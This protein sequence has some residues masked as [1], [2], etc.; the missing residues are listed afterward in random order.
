MEKYN[1]SVNSKNNIKEHDE[2]KY[3][4]TNIINN[5][6]S[7]DINKN[8]EK[9]VNLNEN[10]DSLNNI[11]NNNSLKSIN[12]N[13]E[14]V[15]SL[16]ENETN[17]NIIINNNSL[18]S[19]NKSNEKFDNL[20][21]NK[22]SLNNIINN[23]SINN[24]NKNCK[25][26]DNL[27]ENETNSNIIINNNSLKSINKSDEKVDSLNE[28]KDNLNNIINNDSI[29][30]INKNC[31]TIDSLHENEANSNN[32]I[33]ENAIKNINERY[34]K[35]NI[36]VAGKTGVGKSSLI[37]A[38]FKEEITET[39][40][41]TPVTE[42][43]NEITKN[44]VSIFDS[45]GIVLQNYEK[46]SEELKNF[47]LE[48]K[49]NENE[50]KHIHLAWV[51]IAE[52]SSRIEEAEK[53]LVELL[54]SLDIPVIIVLT[55]SMSSDTKFLEE[56]KNI[57]PKVNDNIIQVHA[58]EIKF[59]D[60]YILKPKN[61]NKLIENTN[62]FLSENKKIS[63]IASQKVFIDI[64]EKTVKNYINE[65]I[66]N[67]EFLNKEILNEEILKEKLINI[68]VYISWIFGI[69][70]EYELINKINDLLF[71]NESF[72]I[73]SEIKDNNNKEIIKEKIK[74]IYKK[75]S[76]SL[77]NLFDNMIKNNSD[78]Y[79]QIENHIT[80]EVDNDKQIQNNNTNSKIN[81]NRDE[82]KENSNF[83][84]NNNSSK[85]INKSDEKVDSLHENEA[86]SNNIIIENAI[87][88]INERYGK[89]NILVA[90][91]TGVGKSS[92]INAIFK[93]EITETGVG[94]PVTENIN[95]ITKNEVSIFDSKGIVLQNYEKVSEELK[96]FILEKKENE[97]ENKHIHL[98]WV[99]IAEGS[100]RIEEAEKDLVELLLSLDIPVIIVLTKSMSSDTKFL[101]EV[102]NICPKVN[103]NIIQ[104]HA[105]EIKFDDGYILK[106][107]NLNKL[108]ENTNKFLSENKKI[109]FIASQK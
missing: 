56:V 28:N 44:E 91:K 92:L 1:N 24:I 106:P 73:L 49:E 5:N 51:C 58:E 16:H 62:K 46:V 22:D 55:K 95:E 57:C 45:K 19:I 102:K 63:F 68:I 100:S 82:N 43:I 50:N 20:N 33:I 15:D 41:G 3:N 103:D 101:E 99:C 72:N 90:G 108:I 64:K 60:G 26:I 2:N 30:N 97:D 17:S 23:D 79:H 80:N 104:V 81:I 76:S 10:K 25:T 89:V 9:V 66:E 83:I 69:K 77:K 7:I 6:S 84:I 109:S 29:N 75:Y 18:K 96:N 21:E 47:I 54:L 74:E 86:N 42:N 11:I 61:L 35:V 39:G 36:L 40:V 13:D 87:K 34:G 93:E 67:D 88:N 105:E 98:A 37:N 32:L 12:N 59:D 38:I 52:G 94:T 70:L 48:K 8:N 65:Q 27:H 85:N 53:D 107:K 78:I 71:Y 31:K 4:S 14:K